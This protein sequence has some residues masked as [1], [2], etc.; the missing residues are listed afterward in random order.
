MNKKE[1]VENEL[2]ALLCA[3]DETIENATYHIVERYPYDLEYVLLEWKSGSNK[4]VYVTADSLV[5]L[6][7][8]VLKA[9]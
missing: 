5:A 4:R 1:F 8:D 6:A 2:L 9:I 3:V 7:R